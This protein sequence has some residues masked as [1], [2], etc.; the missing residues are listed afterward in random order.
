MCDE[1]VPDEWYADPP[2][3][4]TKQK[5]AEPLTVKSFERLKLS[6]SSVLKK[7]NLLSSTG[8]PHADGTVQKR[9]SS[10]RS[11]K[12]SLTLSRFSPGRRITWSG[13]PSP[14]TS[15]KSV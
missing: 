7:L 11:P 1:P 14:L 6:A 10:K 13:R 8:T 3:Q 5:P 9:S 4:T 2:A 12:F 15:S